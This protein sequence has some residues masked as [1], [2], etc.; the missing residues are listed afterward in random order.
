MAVLVETENHI[1]HI[2]VGN[3]RYQIANK[4]VSLVKGAME[5]KSSW[6]VI[7]EIPLNVHLSNYSR[8]GGLSRRKNR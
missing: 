5:G 1:A 3:M 2:P 4:F 7:P 6:S 8:I